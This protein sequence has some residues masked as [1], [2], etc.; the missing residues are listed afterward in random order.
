MKI[1]I[2]LSIG[3]KIYIIYDEDYYEIETIDYINIRI[4]NDTMYITYTTEHDIEVDEE[5][6]HKGSYCTSLEEVRKE[7][8]NDKY[9]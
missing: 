1:N 5:N 7:L 8:E 2:E 9:R 6:L 3:D 4:W